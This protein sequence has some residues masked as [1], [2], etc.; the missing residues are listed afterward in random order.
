M[1]I[2]NKILERIILPLGDLLLGTNFIKHLN[3]WRHV[4]R[5]SHDEL[6]ALQKQN[7]QKLLCYATSEVAFYKSLDLK[8]ENLQVVDYLK[9]FPVI[10]KKIIRRNLDKMV[11]GR[12]EKLIPFYSSGSSGERG[13]VFMSKK[14]RSQVQAIQTLWWEWS[15]YKIGDLLYQT[16]MSPNRDFIKTVKDLLFNTHYIIAF[17][18]GDKMIKKELLSI[19]Q[20]KSSYFMGYASSLYVFAKIALENNIKKIKFKAVVS[21]GDKMFPH[22]RKIIKEAFQ[23]KVTDTYGCTEGLMIAAQCQYGTYHIMDPHVYVEILDQNDKAIPVGEMGRVVVTRLDGYKMPLIRYDLGDIAVLKKSYNPCPC[24]RGFSQMEKVVGR[25]TDIVISPSGKFL[26]VHF[27]TGIFEFI[28]EIKQFKVVQKQKENFLIEY[29]PDSNFNQD[30]LKTA[31]TTMEEKA[32]EKL[33]IIF[34]E[35]QKIPPSPSGKPQIIESTL[36]KEQHATR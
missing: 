13:V 30:V 31:K 27:F 17:G 32:G 1:M 6:K 7:L 23:A 11:V 8:Q 2:Y 9:K 15:G 29:I 4:Q 19:N 35:V 3:Y 28:S 16:G 12:K 36:K 26:I 33:N 10:N 34:Q 20:N 18:L 14:E 22:Y 24:G 21:W 5:M 25:D